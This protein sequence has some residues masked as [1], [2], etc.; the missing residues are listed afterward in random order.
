MDYHRVNKQQIREQV[1]EL[2]GK[3]SL[4]KRDNEQ[5]FSVQEDTIRQ[6]EERILNLR[7]IVKESRQELAKT[8]NKDFEV[9][10]SALQNR[11]ETQLECKRYDAHTARTE[12]NEDVCVQ[13][14]RL[15]HFV[16]QKECRLRRLQDLKLHYRDYLLLHQSNFEKDDQKRLRMLST[17]LDKMTL[18]RNTASFINNTYRK[19]LS[20]LNRDA[21]TMPN[22][23]DQIE[24]DVKLNA[25]ELED[26]KQ[27][28]EVAKK[29]QESSRN[30]R[31]DIE[32]QFYNG[33]QQR[34]K[35]I[36]EQRKIAR[37]N[38]EM[39][40]IEVKNKTYN[41]IINNRKTVKK[42]PTPTEKLEQLGPVIRLFSAITNTSSAKE[43]P[44][45]YNRQI[46]NHK[47]LEEFSKNIVAQLK[48]RKDERETLQKK[49]AQARYQQTQKSLDADKTLKNLNSTAQTVE[50]NRS[51]HQTKSTGIRSVIESVEQGIIA[52]AEKINSV[53]VQDIEFGKEKVHNLPFEKQMEIIIKKTEGMNKVIENASTLSLKL[54]DDENPME[55]LIKNNSHQC[56]ITVENMDED[57]QADTF[58]IDD[59]I[60]NELYRSY[61]DVKGGTMKTNRRK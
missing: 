11:R 49:L 28:H 13:Q 36:T 39:P 50:L 3:L 46:E 60:M 40:D 41:D 15:N 34:D 20:K 17:K 47:E 56:R 48:I 22:Q 19:T 54:T 8:L 42:G 26:L 59:A 6:N 14:K 31:M 24:R 58:L 7:S 61:D 21:L 4:K 53:Q 45:A 43:I 38:S 51:E 52:L 37:E 35:D 23:I 9:I 16:H 33:K 44:Q 27:I 30:Q 1:E 57:S 32:R 5:I 12:L 2:Q 55:Y 10:Q 29:E 25:V 18:K